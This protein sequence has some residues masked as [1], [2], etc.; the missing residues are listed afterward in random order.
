MK[1]RTSVMSKV[2]LPIMLLGCLVGITAAINHFSMTDMH[3]RSIEMLK[4]IEMML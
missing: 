1:I 3:H 4:D 2:I